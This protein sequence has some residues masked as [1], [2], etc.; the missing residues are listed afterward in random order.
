MNGCVCIILPD[1]ES[2][3]SFSFEQIKLRLVL[4][5]LLV[6]LV[7]LVLLLD[8]LRLQSCASFLT[9]AA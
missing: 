6:L 4:L 8:R 5:I 2:S 3:D 7:L 9:A 1:T